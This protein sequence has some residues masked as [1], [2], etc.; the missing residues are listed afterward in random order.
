[1]GISE[2]IKQKKFKSEFNKAIVNLIFTSN[3]LNEQHYKIFKKYGLTVP[4]YNVMRILRGQHPQPVT[5]NTIINRMLDRMSNASRIVDKLEKKKL[6]IRE[7][8]KNDRRAVDVLISDKGLDLLK[9]IDIAIDEWE[10][11]NQNLSND[12]YKLLNQLLDKFREPRV[13]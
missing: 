7:Q 13:P 11:K 12:D 9:Q 6:V 5:V 8:N 3:W 10:D 2:E 1:M 4:Q